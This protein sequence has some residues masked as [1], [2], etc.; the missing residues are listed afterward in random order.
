MRYS[1]A[2]V[3]LLATCHSTLSLG[4]S[5]KSIAAEEHILRFDRDVRPILSDKCI[6]CHGPDAEQRKSQLRLDKENV[7]K[8][9]AIVPGNAQQSELVVRITSNDPDA[10]MPPPDS[11]KQLTA[12]EIATLTRWVDEGADWS[13]H[14][15]FLVPR[16][17]AVPKVANAAWPRNEIDHFVLAQLENKG[18]SP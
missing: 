14:W 16:A 8:K 10:R 3:V 15:S 2:W 17:P 6:R 1:S 7:A 4:V 9:I 18:L 12:E 5:F 13:E 11:N